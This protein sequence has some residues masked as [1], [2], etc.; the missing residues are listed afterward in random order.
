VLDPGGD[1]VKF[2]PGTQNL[3]FKVGEKQINMY[4]LKTGEN[5]AL[6]DISASQGLTDISFSPDQDS[7]ITASKDNSVIQYNMVTGL[8]EKNLLSVKN[9]NVGLA[10]FNPD[11]TLL[12]TNGEKGE[13]LLWDVNQ[14]EIKTHL[15][16]PNNEYPQ[17]LTFSP[18]G[19]FLG[20]GFCV[21]YTQDDKCSKSEVH[22]WTLAASSESIKYPAFAGQVNDLKFNFNGHILAYAA[23][24][25]KVYLWDTSQPLTNQS[26]PTIIDFSNILTETYSQIDHL[27][28]SP[29]GKT[30]AVL[31]TSN[32]NVVLLDIS[33]K[34]QI[35]PV[36]K[37]K[38][39]LSSSSNLKFTPDGSKLIASAVVIDA[40][41]G[42]GI[43]TFDDNLSENLAI[44]PDGQWLAV[45]NESNISL[46]N[47]STQPFQKIML[48]GHSESII[49]LAFTPDSSQLLSLSK[50]F[51]LDQWDVKTGKLLK[52][53]FTGY[54]NYNSKNALSPDG[55]WLV[56]AVKWITDGVHAQAE[57]RFWNLET[58]KLAGQPIRVNTADKIP[59]IV[60]SSDGKVVGAFYCTKKD[61]ET[62]IC[63]ESEISLWDVKTH[64]SLGKI[65]AN[66]LNAITI[67]NKD[68]LFSIDYST[69]SEWTR[70][71]SG[72]SQRKISQ[73]GTSLAVSHDGKVIAVASSGTAGTVSL[74]DIATGNSI[75]LPLQGDFG[76][77]YSLNFSTDDKY[78]AAGTNSDRAYVWQVDP[79]HWVEKACQIV[80][81]NLTQ[82]EWALYLGKLPYQ[83]TCSNNP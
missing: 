21:E 81:R 82:Q 60:F 2:K 53:P 30:L 9:E 17:V 45:N 55:K 63:T 61:P 35:G 78:L 59:N 32:A 15:P 37:I 39:W 54:I 49:N 22:L 29:D 47:L 36:N 52:Q 1:V 27:A 48:I 46:W 6:L 73:G 24:D 70:T 68:H 43:T 20:S 67:L 8:I 18:D 69:V 12:A 26:Q 5:A 38:T 79:V 75:G 14:G 10:A 71:N 16:T 3:F 4:Q 28:L 33:T 23:S 58:G 77:A 57:I 19:K 44:S 56:S 31:D 66:D 64:E 62:T 7:I 41:T 42:Q 80:N 74:W 72:F 25:K 13:I 11:A 65:I 40:H 34:L 76:L 51:T 83:K 50:D